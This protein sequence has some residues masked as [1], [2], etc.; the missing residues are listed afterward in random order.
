MLVTSGNVPHVLSDDPTPDGTCYSRFLLSDISLTFN[1]LCAFP[2]IDKLCHTINAIDRSAGLWNSSPLS[3]GAWADGLSQLLSETKP[4]IALDLTEI[5]IATRDLVVMV[6]SSDLTSRYTLADLLMRPRAQYLDSKSIHWS[7]GSRIHN[8]AGRL[9][10]IGNRKTY[11]SH[12]NIFIR[13]G[14]P[15]RQHIAEAPKR[16]ERPKGTK[17]KPGEMGVGHSQKDAHPL[18]LR[19]ACQQW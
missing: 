1:T 8:F 15:V 13:N 19:Q 3:L 7:A 16:H 18:Q 5:Q 10:P 2:V 12:M 14:K 17:N 11:R 9:R 6:Q 4:T